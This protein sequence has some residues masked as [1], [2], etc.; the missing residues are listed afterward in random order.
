MNEALELKERVRAH[1]DSHSC[2]ESYAA[3]GLQ[4][5]LIKQA[6][7][8]Y[9]FEPYIHDFAKFDE[10]E[11][12]DVLEIGVGMGADHALW[13]RGRPRCLCGIDLTTRA[14]QFTGARL[15][16]EG[17]SSHLCQADAEALP[18]SNETFDLI[19]SWG[20][21]HHSP[22]T[23]AAIMEL[24]RVL[25]SG[26]V[27]RIMLYNRCSLVGFM[28]W[29]RYALMAGR[30]KR[31]LSEVYYHHLES[32]GTKAYKVA[33]VRHLFSRAGFFKLSIRVQL[34]HGDLLQGNVGRRHQ[35]W[36]LSVAKCVWPRR[37]L[38]RFGQRLGLYLLIEAH[39][40]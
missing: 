8:R 9:F 26:G 13:A 38:R 16:S 18:F 22:D 33:E 25:R 28:L 5:D 36:L 17:L 12:K 10:A 31:G 32:P 34:S 19:Y 1:W 3:T 4:L 39:K 21:L 27:A 40:E 2:G 11:N 6:Q 35:G 29:S 14:L 30:V 7:E 20:V 23:P 37:L 15:A 24:S